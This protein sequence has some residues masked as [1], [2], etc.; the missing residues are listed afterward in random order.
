MKEEEKKISNIKLTPREEKEAKLVERRNDMLKK[1]KIKKKTPAEGS[2]E[3]I[4]L[5][6]RCSII[7][8]CIY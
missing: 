1:Y 8:F 4:T 2:A 7:V 5:K 3:S 6:V